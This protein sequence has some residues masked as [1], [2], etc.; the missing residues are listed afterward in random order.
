MVKN[1][2]EQLINSIML[3]VDVFV[4]AAVHVYKAKM[5]PQLL[6]EVHTQSNG[7]NPS[8]VWRQAQLL[9]VI[10]GLPE[11]VTMPVMGPVPGLC[12]LAVIA[13]IAAINFWAAYLTIVIHPLAICI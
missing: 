12:S 2:L 7:C 9:R 11:C 6:N 13:K 8:I 5:E 3:T 10:L 1:L 4:P